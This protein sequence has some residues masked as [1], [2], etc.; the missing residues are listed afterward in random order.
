MQP[1]STC[2]YT[3]SNAVQWKCAA[4]CNNSLC[5]N[6]QEHFRSHKPGKTA[7]QRARQQAALLANVPE[8]QRGKLSADMLNAATGLGMVTTR[9]PQADRAPAVRGFLSP[10]GPGARAVAQHTCRLRRTGV[11]RVAYACVQQAV[12]ARPTGSQDMKLVGHAETSSTGA[13]GQ[14]AL[15]LLSSNAWPR[16]LDKSKPA[17][18]CRRRAARLRIMHPTAMLY[19]CMSACK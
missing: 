3:A 6:A 10:G 4:P 15:G 7:A 14:A 16:C 11:L 18:S 2:S 17:W 12:S 1:C 13:C 8:D 9:S 5:W 19:L